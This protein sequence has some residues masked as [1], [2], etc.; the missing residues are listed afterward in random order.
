M[1]GQY[2]LN[3]HFRA[4]QGEGVHM[5]RAAYFVRLHGCDQSC[6]WC[7]SA[8]T[9]HPKFKTQ[10]PRVT[11]E[12][13]ADLVWLNVGDARRNLPIESPLPFVVV[14]GGEPTM[15]DLG[16]LT[17][18]LRARGFATHLETAGHR[19]ITGDWDWITLSPKPFAAHPLDQSI[20]LADEFKF[21]VESRESLVA[22]AACLMNRPRRPDS[23][24]W[25]HPEWSK[26]DDPEVLRAIC[27][28]VQSPP[29]LQEVRAGWQLHKL[30]GVDRMDPN[31]D[32][33]RIPL[34]GDASRGF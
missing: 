8:G 1:N 31:A 19:P 2:V 20:A 28:A 4:F 11:G 21:I 7:D 23:V 5:G 32:L 12:Q 34:G 14:T 16:E 26:R 27:E 24:V 15:Y 33:R 3:E 25:L 6:P 13:I 10:H 30:Y 17:T 18:A 9:W 29:L 22:S